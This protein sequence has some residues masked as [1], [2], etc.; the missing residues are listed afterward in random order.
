M[1]TSFLTNTYRINHSKRSKN[2]NEK[3][4]F[5]NSCQVA[6]TKLSSFSLLILRAGWY[7][8]CVSLS[9]VNCGHMHVVIFYILINFRGLMKI[10]EKSNPSLDLYGMNGLII[11]YLHHIAI[12]LFPSYQ[13]LSP[14]YTMF[15]VFI[16]INQL[17]DAYILP[18][19]ISQT[20]H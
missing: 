1:Y 8:D 4:S 3:Y 17:L 14:Y 19:H 10:N 12:L 18:H 15:W 20:T 7:Q 16:S 2:D 11:A 5:Q 6:I 9:V 13:I